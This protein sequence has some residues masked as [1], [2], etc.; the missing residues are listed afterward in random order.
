[1]P[2]YFDKSKK[3]YRFTFKRWINGRLIRSSK[4]LPEGWSQAQADAYDRQESAR[5]YAVES[6]IEKPKPEIA[7]VLGL[8]LDHKIPRLKNG[9]KAAQDLAHLIP[10]IDGKRLDELGAIS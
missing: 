9:K 7:E 1:M 10:Y 5:I 3:R 2:N 6:G 8:Y 4:L